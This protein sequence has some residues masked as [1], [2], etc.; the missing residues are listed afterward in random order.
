MGSQ[1]FLG[2]F[3]SLLVVHSLGRVVH[4]H[5]REAWIQQSALRT[6]S[7]T[8]PYNRQSRQ[9]LATRTS[10][11]ARTS[12]STSG[13]RPSVSSRYKSLR[14]RRY[15]SDPDEA[16]P[17]DQE[18]FSWQFGSVDPFQDPS[19]SIMSSP[20]LTPSSRNVLR[21]SELLDLGPFHPQGS[22]WNSQATASS[23]GRV[24]PADMLAEAN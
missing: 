11:S 8:N 21:R 19:S 3:I 24:I 16:Q 20:P 9:S 10:R 18:R 2:A 17:L 15:R 5:E 4:R 1:G 13:W 22:S 14:E 23:S 12:Y 6:R 7:V